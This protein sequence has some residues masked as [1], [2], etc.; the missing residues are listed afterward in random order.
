[1]EH[2][3][4]NG[5]I[6]RG[7]F[8]EW[9]G[10]P[11]SMGGHS[12]SDRETGVCNGNMVL[13]MALRLANK[14]PEMKPP[15]K[16]GLTPK[17]KRMPN[18]TEEWEYLGKIYEEALIHAE[19]ENGK[20]R[21]TNN[22][23]QQRIHRQRNTITVLRESLACSK[24]HADTLRTAIRRKNMIICEHHHSD[25]HCNICSNVNSLES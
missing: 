2:V 16:P 10:E 23:L 25:C 21:S 12:R 1:M 20:L 24:V 11:V 19:S 9:C 3:R 5:D 22:A 15:P 7:W 14:L 8:C 17:G 18:S 13:V 4:P 6:V